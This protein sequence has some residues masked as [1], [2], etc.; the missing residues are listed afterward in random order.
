MNTW[1]DWVSLADDDIATA[2]F[3]VNNMHPVPAHIVCYLCQQAG[4]KYLKGYLSAKT[5]DEP[6]Y[7]H[8]IIA[9]RRLCEKYDATFLQLESAS[10]L[11]TVFATKTRYDKG[12]EVTE[13][14]MKFAIA[15][16]QQIQQFISQRM[17]K[18]S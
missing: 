9:L 17:P 7:T 11:L 13:S 3:L 16:A 15:Y 12:L 8:D 2:E 10:S 4:E 5:A 1:E 18:Q 14:E 6:P